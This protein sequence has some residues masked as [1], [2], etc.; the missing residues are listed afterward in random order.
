MRNGPDAMKFGGAAIALAL[1]GAASCGQQ[2]G[3]DVTTRVGAVVP[4]ANGP[5]QAPEIPPATIPRFQSQLPRFFTYAPKLTR[6]AQ[7]QVTQKE[8]TV[9]IDI[10]DGG[11]RVKTISHLIRQRC[12]TATESEAV[13]RLSGCFVIETRLGA[14][15]LDTPFTCGED[16]WRMVSVLR[17]TTSF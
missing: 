9:R 3:D 1:F 2:P 12:W 10:S 6:N 4:S 17:K 5:G 16:S 7:G 11:T 13:V 14:L 15:D 8:F